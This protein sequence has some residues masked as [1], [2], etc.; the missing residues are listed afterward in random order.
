MKRVIYTFLIIFIAAGAFAQ[1]STDSVKTTTDSVK[2]KR[3]RIRVT[4]G[5]DVAKT[6]KSEPDTVY[7]ASKAP[8]FSFGLTFTRFD[9]GLTALNDNGSFT[10]SPVNQVLNY[11]SW[12]TSYIGFDVLQIGYRFSSSFRI[13][14][15]G[16]FD[17][18]NIRLRKSGTFLRDAPVLTFVPDNVNYDVN[19]LSAT[20][21]RVPLSFD[22]RT[23]DDADGRRFHIVVGPELGVLIG[24]RIKQKSGQNGDLKLGGDYHFTKFRYGAVARVGYGA[25]GLFAKYYA[26]NMFDNS[27]AQDG[28]RQFAFGLSVGW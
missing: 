4:F 3:K 23:H 9:I 28:L 24:S 11:R 5:N 22:F 17:W 6:N 18:T 12:R 7:H 20:Y 27:P 25:I 13:Y 10:L 2:V 15:A 8:G 14:A 16:G 19:R 21:I 1:S 26:N